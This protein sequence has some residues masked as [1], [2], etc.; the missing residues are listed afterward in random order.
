MAKKKDSPD[1]VNSNSQLYEMRSDALEWQKKKGGKLYALGY[2]DFHFELWRGGSV[3]KEHNANE[4]KRM[5]LGDLSA[6]MYLW[7]R[8]A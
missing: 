2:I 1:N 8:S 5:L 4:F 3:D 7:N 6:Y